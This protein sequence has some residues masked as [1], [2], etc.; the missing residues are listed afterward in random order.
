MGRQRSAGAGG[1]EPKGTR[2]AV[3]TDT[4]DAACGTLDA[5]RLFSDLPWAADGEWCPECAEL[6]PFD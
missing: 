5:L 1:R 4:G 6:V 2:H 3:D